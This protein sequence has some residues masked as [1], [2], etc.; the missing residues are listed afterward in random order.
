[1]QEILYS[2][3][4]LIIRLPKCKLYRHYDEAGLTKLNSYDFK[5]NVPEKIRQLISDTEILSV[6]SQS[7]WSTLESYKVDWATF[8]TSPDEKLDVK[9]YITGMEYDALNRV[10][11]MVYPEDTDTERKILLIIPVKLSHLSGL[12]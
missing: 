9:E 1:V 2:F 7:N 4:I 3:L 11:K 6:F 12:N 10:T 8:T 5:G